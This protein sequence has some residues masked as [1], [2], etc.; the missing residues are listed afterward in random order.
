[1]RDSVANWLND[2]AKDQPAFVR[3]TCA[4]W[5][6]ESQTAETAYIAKR[7]LRSIGAQ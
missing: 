3:E 5:R 4:R 1:V 2:A 6:R 7:A